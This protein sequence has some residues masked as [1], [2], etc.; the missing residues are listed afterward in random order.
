VW[1][2]AFN[3]DP[4]IVNVYVRSLR[5]KIDR[6]FKRASLQ[7]VR[8]LG[9][10]IRDDTV[11]QAADYTPADHRVWRQRGD[12]RARLE[13]RRGHHVP[14]MTRQGP[15]VVAVGTSLQNRHDDLARLAATLTIA[16]SAA[17][18]L[19]SAGAWLALAGALRPVERM[20]RQAA[21]ISASN[22]GRRL[23]ATG[24]K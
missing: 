6:P 3:G 17:L 24:G 14:V 19:I 2:F 1:D 11:A 9:Y 13:Q 20:R 5:D 7:T 22:P 15:L 23:S 21:A 4:R 12:H 8:G 18:L 16:G 10:R